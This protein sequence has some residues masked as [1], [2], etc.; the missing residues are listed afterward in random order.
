MQETCKQHESRI[1]NLEKM[2]RAMLDDFGKIKDVLLPSEYHP[3]NG[4]VNQFVK[5][6]Q[7]LEEIKDDIQKMKTT[8]ATAISIVG[9]VVVI[10]ELAM[11]FVNT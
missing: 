2:S 6:K 4:L 5:Q 3:D 11:K 7:Q 8:V 10:I 9:G 1:E